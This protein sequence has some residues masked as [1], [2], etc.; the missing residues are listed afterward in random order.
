MS[1]TAT[2]ATATAATATAAA[3]EVVL[4]SAQWCK[5][6]HTLKPEIAKLCALTGVKLTV[7]DYD[8]LEDSI[9]KAEVK[10]LPSIFL[11]ADPEKA[12]KLY[13]AAEFDSWK[14][15]IATLGL[16]STDG[17]TDF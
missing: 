2:A 9:L 3:A 12:W 10:S 17:S 8:E 14:S 6:C 5:R 16:G 11:R 13:T 1:A 15:D 7:L 4:V